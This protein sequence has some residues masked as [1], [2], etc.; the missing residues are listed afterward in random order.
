MSEIEELSIPL[1]IGGNNI[2]YY[3]RIGTTPYGEEEA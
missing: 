1:L 2:A 3:R